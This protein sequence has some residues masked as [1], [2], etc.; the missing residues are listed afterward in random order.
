MKTIVF[1][2]VSKGCFM[3]VTMYERSSNHLKEKL[4]ENGNMSWPEIEGL[5]PKYGMKWHPLKC[6]CLR[7][8]VVWGS[9]LMHSPLFVF[10]NV[11]VLTVD[12]KREMNGTQAA[13]WWRWWWRLLNRVK[14]AHVLCEFQFWFSG[15]TNT[16]FD[17]AQ[18]VEGTR[19]KYNSWPPD[20]DPFPSC[21][22]PVTVLLKSSPLHYVASKLFKRPLRLCEARHGRLVNER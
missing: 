21:L 18:K 2:R 14:R 4:E 13:V 5:L 15:H 22:H 9:S 3:T 12:S 7:N 11:N 19:Q 1:F 17:D 16:L 20:P 8:G 10:L 6:S